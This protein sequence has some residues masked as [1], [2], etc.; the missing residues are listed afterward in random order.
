MNETLKSHMFP[1]FF[2]EGYKFDMTIADPNT[3]THYFGSL[4]NNS[5]TTLRPARFTR[6]LSWLLIDLREGMLLAS[7]ISAM[8]SQEAKLGVAQEYETFLSSPNPQNIANAIYGKMG[9]HISYE[10][11]GTIF[12]MFRK[13]LHWT[14]SFPYTQRSFIRIVALDPKSGFKSSN[15]LFDRSWILAR[16]ETFWSS[17]L[18]AYSTVCLSMLSCS[19][20]SHS[21]PAILCHIQPV[22][23]HYGMQA[24]HASP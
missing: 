10:R 14:D 3:G 23:V 5:V 16:R 6:L 17:L 9:Y 24:F 11:W 8:L 20:V 4:G 18:V 2:F 15:L 7:D 21:Y 22:C 19:T 12:E 13:W 1:R